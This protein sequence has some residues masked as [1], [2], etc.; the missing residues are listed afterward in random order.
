[1]SVVIEI[2]SRI[3]LAWRDFTVISAKNINRCANSLKMG[4]L[5]G[6]LILYHVTKYRAPHTLRKIRYKTVSG[7]VPFQKV[8]ICTFKVLI[9]IN[10]FL[11]VYM[12][13]RETW[14]ITQG[15]LVLV[16]Q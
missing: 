3:N 15:I 16:K 6:Q 10:N 5:F 12:A 8:L 1:M 9:I 11:G 13:C 2:P 14:G 4:E 7:R